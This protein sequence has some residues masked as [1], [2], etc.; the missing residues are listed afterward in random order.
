[1]GAQQQNTLPIFKSS[2]SITMVD[3]NDK[4]QVK[5]YK[6]QHYKKKTQE[7]SAAENARLETREHKRE[8]QRQRQRQYRAKRRTMSVSVRHWHLPTVGF[9]SF[10]HHS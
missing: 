7:K 3:W 6:R 9:L 4:Q 8:L 5:E 2:S 1:L 10:S